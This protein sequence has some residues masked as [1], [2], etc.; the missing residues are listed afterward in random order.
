MKNK[1]KLITTLLVSIGVLCLAAGAVFALKLGGVFQK[2]KVD[3]AWYEEDGKE[4]LIT[5]AEE[6]RGIAKLSKK[7]D[8][9]GQTIKLGADIVLNEGDYTQWKKEFLK[10][11]WT[12]IEG[13][14]GTFDGDGHTISG[15]YCVAN[16]F[17][18]VGKEVLWNP[19]GMF[20]DSTD[21]AVIRDFRIVNS[22]YT[23]SNKGGLGSVIGRGNGTIDSVYSSATLVASASVNGGLV[24]EVREGGS[25]T[26]KNCQFDGEMLLRGQNTVYTGGMIGYVKSTKGLVTIEHC[27]F[28]GEMITEQTSGTLDVGGFIGFTLAK[29]RVEMSDC[30]AS[31]KIDTAHKRNVG[32]IL[33]SH[34][35]AIM[36]MDNVYSDIA[37]MDAT[38]GLASTAISSYPLEF[39]SDCFVGENALKWTELDFKKYWTIVEDGAPTLR[40]FAD[41]EVDSQELPKAYNTEWFDAKKDTYTISTLD[42]FYGF[43][44]LS[45]KNA[46]KGKT[47]KLGADIKVNEGT[48]AQWKKEAPSVPYYPIKKFDGTFDGDGHTISGVYLKTAQRNSGLFTETGSAAKLTNF[49]L[50]NSYFESAGDGIALIGSIVGVLDGEMNTVYSDAVVAADALIFGGLAGNVISTSRATITNCWYDGEIIVGD[51]GG[52]VGGITGQVE[53]G[54][55]ARIMHSLNSGNITATKEKG[56]MTM[57]GIAGVI[58]DERTKVAITDCLNVGTV[59]TPADAGIGSM[60]STI[61]PKTTVTL[62]NCYATEESCRSSVASKHGKL[63]GGTYRKLAKDLSG[64]KAY[65]WTLLDFDKYW[66]VVKNGT[67]ILQS[68]ADN[69]PSVAGHQRKINIDWYKPKDKTYTLKTAADL[70]GFYHMSYITDFEG[71]TVQ[72]GKDITVN[73]GNAADWQNAEPAAPWYTI[74]NF[75][76]TFD[77][78]G[79]TISGIYMKTDLQGRGLFGSTTPK[80]VI[81]NLRLTNSYF[82]G[83]HKKAAQMGSV[84]GKLQGRI[85]G[86]YSNAIVVADTL[87]AGGIVGDISSKEK[88]VISNCWFD[89]SMKIGNNGGYVGGIVGEAQDGTVAEISHCLNTGNIIGTKEKGSLTMGGIIGVI[90][91]DNTKVTISDTL[92]AGQVYTPS[93]SGIGAICSTILQKT[94][95]VF[96]NCYATLESC[97]GSYASKHGTVEGACYRRTAADMS[98]Y[99]AYEWTLLNFDKY[100]AVVEGGT[101]VLKKFAANVPSVAGHER[102]INIDWYKKNAKEYVLKTAN[103]LYGFYYMTYVTDFADKIVKLGAD[104]TVNQGNAADWQNAAPSATWYSIRN[105]AGT[106]DGQGHTISGIYMKT[107]I[108]GS[109]LF[110]STTPQTVIKNFRLTNSYFEGTHAKAAQIGSVVGKGQGT[111]DTIYSNAIVVAD[112]LIAGGIIGDISSKE[113]VVVTN[114]WYDGTMKI[115]DNGGYVGGITGEVQDGTVAEINH[116]LNIGTITGTKEKGSLT[117]GG[118]VGVISDDNTK[119]TIS[120]TLNAGKVY[121]PSNTGFGAMFSTVLQKTTVVLDNCYA[122]EES[123]VRSYASKHGTVEGTCYRKKAED[124]SGY[125]AYEWTFLDFND[126]WAV[127]ETDTPIL[128]TFAS[129]VPSLAGYERKMDISWYKEGAKTHVLK[130]AADLYGFYYIS[131]VTDFK[132]Q[133][134]KLGRDIIINTGSAEDWK[135]SAPENAWYPIRTFAGTFDGQG[136]TISGIYLKTD[137]Q[138]RGLF[139]DTTATAVLKDFRLENSYFESTCTKPAMLGSIVGKGQGTFDTIYSDAIVVANTVIAGGIIG[140]IS[141]NEKVVVTNCW[142]DGTMELG[143]NSGYIGGIAGEVQDGTNAEIS[144]CLNTGT[145]TGAGEAMTMAGIVG[146]LADEGTEVTVKDTLAAGSVTGKNGAIGAIASTVLQ[147]TT[148]NIDNCYATKESAPKVVHKTHGTQNGRCYAMGEGSIS[149]QG[150]YRWTYL[151]FVDYWTVSDATPELQSFAKRVAGKGEKVDLTWYKED[152]TEFVIDSLEELY[153]MYYLSYDTDFAGKTIRLGTDIDF[154]GYAWTPIAKFAGTFDGLDAEGNMH[155]IKNLQMKIKGVDNVAFFAQTTDTTVVKNVQFLNADISGKKSVATIA[156]TGQGTFQNIN[157]TGN[158]SGTG[159]QCAG[160]L[161]SVTT[162]EGKTTLIENCQYI[163]NVKSTSASGY[164]G[165]FIGYL[166]DSASAENVIIRNCNVTGSIESEGPYVGG[167]AGYVDKNNPLSIEDS[168]SCITTKASAYAG[169]S[170]GMNAGDTATTTATVL[171]NVFTTHKN[172]LGYGKSKVSSAKSGLGEDGLKGNNAYVNTILDFDNIWT[173]VENGYPELRIFAG[174]VADAPKQLNRNITADEKI[175]FTFSAGTKEEPYVLEDARDLLGFANLSQSNTFEGKYVVLANDIVVNNDNAVATNR[176]TWVPIGGKDS[177]SAFKGNFDGCGHTISGLYYNSTSVENAGFFKCIA[178]G[179]NER[180]TI[181]DFTLDNVAMTA[182][183]QVGAVAGVIYGGIY[184]GIRLT[185]TVSVKGTRVIGGIAGRVLPIASVLIEECCFEGTVEATATADGG[186]AGG[187][188][189]WLYR[190]SN[191]SSLTV[192]NCL[193]KGTIKNA[194]QHSGGACGF[195]EKNHGITVENTLI[196]SEFTTGSYTGGAIGMNSGDTVATTNTILNNVYTTHANSLGYGKSKASNSKSGMEASALKGNNAYVN[197]ILDFDEVWTVVNDEY[198]ELRTFASQTTEAPKKVNRVIAADTTTWVVMNAGTKEDPYVLKDARDLLGLA[199]LSQ[200]DTYDGKYFV[201]A[202]DITVNADNAVELNRVAWTP[203][204]GKDSNSAFKGSFDGSGHTISGL[205]YKNAGVENVGFFACIANGTTGSVEI[206][207]FTLDNVNITASKQIGAV[208]GVIYGGT[209]QGIHLAKDVEIKG[210]RVVGGIA[211]RVLPIGDVLLEQCYF[212]GT[213]EA[214]ATADGGYAGGLMGWLYRTSN[215]SQVNVNNCLVK[216]TIKNAHQYSG[217]VCGYVQKNHGITVGNTL[218]VSEFET[219]VY[220]G[221][222]VGMNAGDTADTTNTILDNVYTTHKNSLGYGKSETSTA[223]SQVDPL[224]LKD[225]AAQ[226]TTEFN[227]DTIWMIIPND[228]PMLRA[229]APQTNGQ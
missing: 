163:G 215:P 205:Y 107:D 126:Y 39:V 213:V 226:S 196:V 209:Y 227:Y 168:L 182:F 180:V 21:D 203:I 111:F 50:T 75:A 165:G 60:L 24:G 128:Q 218:I 17:S 5:T 134:V 153:G 175:W 97:A 189:G 37:C 4:F 131:Y 96:D 206:K 184:E 150:G 13:F 66:A 137:I 89:G 40:T 119:V 161:G 54:S 14:A 16:G 202:N 45:A 42:E 147:D 18:V 84:V 32:S 190:T 92:N 191:P 193:V 228:Y 85:E 142:Y 100:W 82:E 29:S 116:C 56:S 31:G 212:E 34:T 188:V 210:T 69:V 33:G 148:L 181:K 23:S 224:T 8:F 219:G 61:L 71:K 214:T 223:K 86:V 216:G 30:L 44:V 199:T 74:L 15:L 171:D 129:K 155:A 11:S 122:T 83:T 94:T 145:I 6:L 72:L 144:H 124:L 55:H 178:N 136:K 158:V 109:G 156:A 160:L 77:G 108:Q 192:N 26:M 141:S 3:V 118:I 67:P 112:T 46:F 110:G 197:T 130:T 207:N 80:T 68:F 208:A 73:K 166:R 157:V 164:V 185:D 88:V 201:L 20:V 104:I 49:K 79:R 59:S 179:T 123:C 135:T 140:D 76:G 10:S 222:V 65:E 105:F 159:T 87:I 194:H 22:Y 43:Y 47:I 121:A 106:F 1:K 57:G 186:Y 167:F 170:V 114:C 9:K 91:D 81:K 117:M 162:S 98:G 58:S 187:L 152:Q 62:E 149:G 225:E 146:V 115:G 12:P 133:T 151:D 120:D 28:S 172:T 211:G 93:K 51:G 95:L 177:N 169:G 139:T 53:N 103:D 102:K 176:L 25:L 204:G 174:K 132:G 195:V 183:K 19:S 154:T 101:P 99:M 198:P 125:Q 27:L 220:T 127:V 36:K 70:Y 7:H 173:V 217:G 63:E 41:K 221:G 52:Y 35:G 113:K 78:R 143:K 48:V 229:F 200:S 90:A 2:E 64:Y 138:G 38:V